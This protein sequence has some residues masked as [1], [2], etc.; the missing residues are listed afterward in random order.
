[1]P[2]LTNK[3]DIYQKNVT[4]NWDLGDTTVINSSTVH[5]VDVTSTSSWQTTFDINRLTSLTPGHQYVFYLEV[6]SFD[7][8]ALSVNETVITG[9][10]CD[11]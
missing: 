9:I 11:E 1:M 7:K 6:T 5:Y 8:T 2:T 3:T 4:L 10:V